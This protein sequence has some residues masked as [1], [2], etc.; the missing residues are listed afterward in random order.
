MHIGMLMAG[1]IFLVAGFV[2]APLLTTVIPSSPL[3]FL[4]IAAPIVMGISAI[5]FSLRRSD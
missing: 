4:F 1:I 5:I 2:L 3:S